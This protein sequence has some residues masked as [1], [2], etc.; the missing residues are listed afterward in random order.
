M[1]ALKAEK[2]HHY[3]GLWGRLSKEFI[4][5]SSE[6][7]KLDINFILHPDIWKFDG[8]KLNFDVNVPEVEY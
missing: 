6:K 7:V 1:K 2:G 8:V 3:E 5:T 4:A